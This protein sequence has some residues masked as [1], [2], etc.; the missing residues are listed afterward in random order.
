MIR[1]FERQKCRIMKDIVQEN[2]SVKYW[3]KHQGSRR[4]VF[5]AYSEYEE[6]KKHRR[7]LEWKT[8]WSFLA[9]WLGYVLLRGAKTRMS[10]IGQIFCWWW[11]SGQLRQNQ[12]MNNI[13]VHCYSKSLL[14][15]NL[16]TFSCRFPNRNVSPFNFSMYNK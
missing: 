16:V 14:P 3:E 5:D 11:H 8:N 1:R 13:I 7:W 4:P 2:I 15:I 6:S 9:W 10:I 12:H